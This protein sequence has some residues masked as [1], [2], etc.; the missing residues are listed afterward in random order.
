MPWLQVNGEGAFSLTASLVYVS[1]RVVEHLEHRDDPVGM[2]VSPF[3]VAPSGPDVANA[4]PYSSSRFRDQSALFKGII[5]AFDGIRLH[6]QQEA[7]THLRLWRPA[8]K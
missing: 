1:G 3:N 4:D 2:A 6:G 8:I 7:G 5:D